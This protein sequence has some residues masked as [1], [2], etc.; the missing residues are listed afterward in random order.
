M[1]ARSAERRLSWKSELMKQAQSYAIDFFSDD[2]DRYNFM[3]DFYHGVA[4]SGAEF[5]LNSFV[6]CRPQQFLYDFVVS[7]CRLYDAS[8]K[9]DVGELLPIISGDFLIYYF[10]VRGI[11]LEKDVLETVVR[12]SVDLTYIGMGGTSSHSSQTDEMRRELVSDFV[13]Y[14]RIYKEALSSSKLSNQV[15]GVPS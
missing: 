6:K 7:V 12:E 15:E 9:K 13:Q 8:I 4:E 11:P 5:D 10:E 1:E 2:R 14:V 3:F